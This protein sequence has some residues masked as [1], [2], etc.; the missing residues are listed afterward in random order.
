MNQL[1]FISFIFL[2]FSCKYSNNKTKDIYTETNTKYCNIHTDIEL[3]KSEN[4]DVYYCQICE[5]DKVSKEL[6]EE[7]ES[8]SYESSTEYSKPDDICNVCGKELYIP[9]NRTCNYCNNYFDG[10]SYILEDGKLEFEFGDVILNCLSKDNNDNFLSRYYEIHNYKDWTINKNVY[11][12]KKCAI[13][14]LRYLNEY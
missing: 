8:G 4:S 7:M 1:V 12:S 6:I 2:I 13:D 14:Y 9:K 11:C 10:W 3:V 5:N